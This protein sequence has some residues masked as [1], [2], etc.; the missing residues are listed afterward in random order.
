MED[1]QSLLGL[2]E[3]TVLVLVKA[4]MEDQP[5]S[6]ILMVEVSKPEGE[7]V[8]KIMEDMDGLV[9]VVMVELED[10]MEVMVELDYLVLVV[11]DKAPVSYLQYRESQ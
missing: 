2:E 11:L 4:M 7:V 1:C 10:A 3:D 9:E 8:V 6:P 5:L